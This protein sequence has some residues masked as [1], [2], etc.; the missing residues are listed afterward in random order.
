MCN[1]PV[2]NEET[3]SLLL[4]HLIDGFSDCEERDD[5]D[6][7]DMLDLISDDGKMEL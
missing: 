2:E 3:V 1:S 5:D 7:C 6:S 4:P